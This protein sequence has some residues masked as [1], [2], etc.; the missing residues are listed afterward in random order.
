MVV[1][2]MG[3]PICFQPNKLSQK[4]TVCPICKKYVEP[5][6]CAFYNCMWRYIGTMRT[7]KEPERRSSDW[8]SAGDYYHRFD[9]FSNEKWQSLVLETKFDESKYSKETEP[10]N[11]IAIKLTDSFDCA[12]CLESTK[13]DEIVQFSNCAHSSHKS[14]LTSWDLHFDTCSVCWE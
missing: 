1:M 9:E 11:S 10:S 14:C 5:V 7:G 8:T 13:T 2:N 3:L 6:K 4:P 12:I